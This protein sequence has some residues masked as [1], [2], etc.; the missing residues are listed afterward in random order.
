M[1]GL[2]SRLRSRVLSEGRAH[3]PAAVSFG[4]W[5]AGYEELVVKGEQDGCRPRKQ[6]I[7]RPAGLRTNP[8]PFRSPTRPC[9]A[10]S[11]AP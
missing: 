6:G 4:G 11:G 8:N 10:R 5:G 3:A 1:E 9:Q 7:T 2:R